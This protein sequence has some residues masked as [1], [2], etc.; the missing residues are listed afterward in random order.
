LI[1]ALPSTT[2]ARSAPLARKPDGTYYVRHRPAVG[3]VPPSFWNGQFIVLQ[4]GRQIVLLDDVLGTD[5][6]RP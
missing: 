3:H 4:Q 6:P 1:A 2:T 5:L